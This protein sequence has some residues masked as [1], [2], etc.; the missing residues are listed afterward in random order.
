MQHVRSTSAGSI[1]LS[2]RGLLLFLGAAAA[3]HAQTNITWTG[4]TNLNWNNANNW[5]P[6]NVPNAATEL[7]IFSASAGSNVDFDAN[8]TIGGIL[9]DN[10]AGANTVARAGGAGNERNL[11]LSGTASWNGIRSTSASNQA[12]SGTRLTLALGTATTFEVGGAGNLNVS[13]T[14]ATDITL[15]ANTLTLTGNG[16]GTG[17]SSSVISGTGS[18]VKT[19]TG[20][21]TLSGANTF[22]GTT[23]ISG[24]TLAIASEANLGANPAAANAGQLTL[25]GGTLQTTATLSIDDSNRGLTVTGSG[26]LSPNAGTT[27]TV[28]NALSGSGTLQKAGAGTLILSGDSSSTFSGAVA[29]NAGTLQLGASNR[30]ATTS[31]VSIASGA[32]FALGGFSQTIGAISGLGLLDLASA[33]TL[34]IGTGNVASTFGGTLSGNG[35]LVKTGSGALTFNQAIDFASGTLTLS[36]GSLVLGANL[37]LGTLRITSDTILDFGTGGH[38][39]TAANV[40]VDPNVTVT[41]NN[42]NYLQDFFYAQ[43]SFKQGTTNLAAAFNTPGAAPQNQIVFTA[44]DLPTEWRSFDRQ[45]SPAPEPATYGAIFLGLAG[46]LVIWRRRRA[47]VTSA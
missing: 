41:V 13:P 40:I 22:S 3:A 17:T 38:T 15:G 29:I 25:S 47:R 35:N 46:S 10:T 32:T 24:G 21:W 2:W 1:G 8:A 27:L 37:T 18:L 11:T 31:A 12:I 5:S 19:G 44:S 45:I 28:A 43:T 9:F 26:T 42:W 14:G 36:G 39:L 7:A 34:T 4:A 30:L 16:S 33:S 6:A 20:T 23:T